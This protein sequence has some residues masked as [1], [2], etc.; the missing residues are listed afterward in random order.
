MKALII[1]ENH[2]LQDSTGKVWCER[3]VDYNYLKRYLEVFGGII[4]C[5]RCRNIREVDKSK[6][7]KISGDG[8]EFLPLP[9]FKGSGGFLKN[10]HRIQESINEALDQVDCVIMRA[11]THLAMAA[12][13]VIVKRNIPFALEFMMAA[14]RMIEGM[15]LLKYI[16]NPVINY[17]FKRICRKADGVSYVTA[18]ILQEKYPCRAILDPGNKNF[19]TANYSSIDLSNSFYCERSVAPTKN[20]C[21]LIHVGYMDSGRKGQDIAILATKELR[22]IGYNVDLSLVGDG[23]KRKDFEELAKVQ[24]IEKYVHFC[25]GVK[26]K[27]ELADILRQADIFVFPTISEGLPRVV[28][29]AMANSL[30]CLATPVDGIPELLSEDF[31]VEREPRA[32]ARKIEYLLVHPEVVANGSKDNYEKSLEYRKELID[33]RRQMFYN[34]LKKKCNNK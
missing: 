25:G 28:I 30:V 34:E 15:G 10:Y 14:N 12:Y 16:I 6:V 3:V 4:V 22:Q 1:L 5:G 27:K 26:N 33:R 23:D 13:P 32:Y 11:P 31:L 8:V 18:R 29:E 9:D 2:F 19:F 21:R 7:L 24:G 17:Q 20:N